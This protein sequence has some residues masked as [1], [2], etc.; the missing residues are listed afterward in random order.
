MYVRRNFPGFDFPYEFV[1]DR[2]VREENSTIKVPKIWYLFPKEVTYSDYQYKSLCSLILG[3]IDELIH[4]KKDRNKKWHKRY[5]VSNQ[6]S[7]IG[8]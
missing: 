6:G 2:L 4:D 8:S 7:K 1:C 5:F 3:F